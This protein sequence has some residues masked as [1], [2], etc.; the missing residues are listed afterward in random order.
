MKTKL[1]GMA[2][3][4]LCMWAFHIGRPTTGFRPAWATVAAP[5]GIWVHR[6]DGATTL[7]EL[8]T[9]AAQ[10]GMYVTRDGAWSF[11]CSRVTGCR[12]N[13]AGWTFVE[14]AP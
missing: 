7:F 13:G 3:V 9:P 12:I 1:F 11:A 10:L 5:G 4:L 14:V 6:R 2:V 8:D